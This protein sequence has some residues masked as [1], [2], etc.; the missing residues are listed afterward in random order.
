MTDLTDYCVCCWISPSFNSICQP[1]SVRE[2]RLVKWLREREG[3]REGG[4]EGGRERG[5]E[6]GMERWMNGRREEVRMGGG[7]GDEREIGVEGGVEV[8]GVEGG[9]E[10]GVEEEED[11]V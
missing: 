6:R 7:I 8:K 4:R 2:Y 1:V 3:E 10:G 5:R 9:V 11:T